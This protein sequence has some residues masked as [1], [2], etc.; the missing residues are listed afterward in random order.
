MLALQFDVSRNSHVSGRWLG[1]W[2]TNDEIGTLASQVLISFINESANGDI[3]SDQA[4]A[5]RHD[6]KGI[7]RL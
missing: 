3:S 1:L 2:T 7:L 5:K 6:K 4:H